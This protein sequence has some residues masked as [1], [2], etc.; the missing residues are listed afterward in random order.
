M[1]TRKKFLWQHPDGRWYVRIKARYFRIYAAEGTPDFDR[2][3]WEILTGKRTQAKTSFNAL[4]DDYLTSDR[5]KALKPRTRAD[6]EKVLSY[7]REKIG[8]RDV[9]QLTRADVIV[10]QKANAHRTRFANYIPQIF[11][12]LCEHAIDLGW[13]VHNPAKGVRALK[14]PDD[15]KREH[16][17]W[18]DWA[19][20][21][22]RAEADEVPRLIF[23][24]GVGTV[25]RPGD[26]PGFNWDDYDPSGDGTLRLRQNKTDKP[27][28]LP[29]TRPLKAVLDEARAR[30]DF[31]PMA[32]RPILCGATGGRM[33]YRYMAEI[34]LKERRRLGLEAFDLHALRYRGIKELAWAGCN[35]DEIASYSGHA[36]TRMIA[37]YA[38]EAR[39]EMRAR[40]AR[41]KRQ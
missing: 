21:K 13:I 11:V 36:T 34:M 1:V 3:Y 26:W 23:E 20:E 6:Y 14:T 32:G 5:W 30:L 4:I 33:G 29:C 39:Q 41:L 31:V 15:R 37:K 22:F 9:K 2:E 25:Q 24:L 8:S 12:I 19:V 35:D 10:A 16:V 38:G 40:Q 18:P 27:L 7:F 28:V 17:P